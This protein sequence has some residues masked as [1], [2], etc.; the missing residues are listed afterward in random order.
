MGINKKFP[1]TAAVFSNHITLKSVTV[2]CR[3]FLHTCDSV[4]VVPVMLLNVCN[5]LVP[6]LLVDQFFCIVLWG[7]TTAFANTF[8]V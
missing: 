3:K 8:E 2:V 7:L 1:Q 5:G 6:F 4:S